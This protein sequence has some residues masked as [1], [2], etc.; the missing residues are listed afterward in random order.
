MTPTPN[1]ASLK[2]VVDPTIPTDELRVHPSMFDLLQ[3]AFMEAD[4]RLNLFRETG[5]KP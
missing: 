3:R 2:V 1:L 4:N 5:E